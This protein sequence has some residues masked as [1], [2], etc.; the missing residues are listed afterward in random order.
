MIMSLLYAASPAGR[1]GEAVGVRTT[2]M[3]ASHTFLPL[4]FGTVAALG[5]APVFWSMSA[6]LLSGAA[7]VRW[8]ARR[9]S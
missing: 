8:R 2:M 9:A 1:Q 5:M 7:F 4:V 6:L 3:N